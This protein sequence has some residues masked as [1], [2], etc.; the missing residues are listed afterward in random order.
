MTRFMNIASFHAR[1]LRM[2]QPNNNHVMQVA[3]TC[4]GADRTTH[5]HILW[6]V[7]VRPFLDM[8]VKGWL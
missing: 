2:S 7:N 1:A 3:A 6:D 4:I 5:N 8:S